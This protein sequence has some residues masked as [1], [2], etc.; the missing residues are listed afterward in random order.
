MKD[1]DEEEVSDP[2]MVG[3]LVS[4]V[5]GSYRR[6]EGEDV[7]EGYL[8]CSHAYFKNLF[9]YVHGHHCYDIIYM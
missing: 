9:E 7:R 3:I 1:V 8:D 2:L 4:M 6:E 5:N